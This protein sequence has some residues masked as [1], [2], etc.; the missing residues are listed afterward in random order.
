MHLKMESN[1]RKYIWF[2]SKELHTFKQ[3]DVDPLGYSMS[4][5]QQPFLNSCCF[6]TLSEV[7]EF[8]SVRV[9]VLETSLL[10]NV[11]LEL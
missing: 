3:A 2:V 8:D 11:W 9:T 1:I 5:V 7:S 6:F 4:D 10:S